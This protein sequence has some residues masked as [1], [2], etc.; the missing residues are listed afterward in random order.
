MKN[1]NKTFKKLNSC[2]SFQI[3]K[4]VYKLTNGFELDL[5]IDF[6]NEYNEYYFELYKELHKDLSIGN[7]GFVNEKGINEIHYGLDEE[8]RQKIFES[9]GVVYLN[10]VIFKFYSYN[11]VEVSKELFYRY[12]NHKIE[13]KLKDDFFKIEKVINIIENIIQNKNINI[14]NN[15]SLK[16]ID[17][18]KKPKIITKN[19]N[20]IFDPN[21]FNEICYN[22]FCYLVDNYK[23]NGKIKFINIYYY[24]KDEVDKEKYS[25]KFIQSEYTDFINDKYLIEI[26]KYQKATYDF[27]EQKRVLNSLEE[28]FRR[29]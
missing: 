24:L 11:G 5:L 21:N 10:E 19:Q 20:N 14:I 26:K 8:L 7:V 23:K 27:D 2:S 4:I 13:N 22:L 28:Q 25:F 17:L 18:N 15:H 6:I 1:I 9:N 16:E 12:L 29:Q 3:K